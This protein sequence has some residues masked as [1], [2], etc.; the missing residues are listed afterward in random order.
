MDKLQVYTSANLL[1]FT[2]ERYTK[3]HKTT[4]CYQI[5]FWIFKGMVVFPLH[6]LYDVF[7]GGIDLMYKDML[8][9]LS[10]QFPFATSYTFW[11]NTATFTPVATVKVHH[12]RKNVADWDIWYIS[13]SSCSGRIRFD[14]C[15]LCHQNEI[16]PSIS[17]SVVLCVFVL[18]VYI[19]VLV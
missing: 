9:F 7:I 16:S 19:V 11:L 15:S 2:A 4:P 5:R 3:L 18:L 13:S 12:N 1:L 17:S 10:P 8:W 6:I 14:S